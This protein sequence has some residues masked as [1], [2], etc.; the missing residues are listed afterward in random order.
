VP[1]VDLIDETFLVALPVV[2]AAACHD[3]ARTAAWWPDL[4]LTVFQDRGVDGIRW[5]VTGALVG[6]AELWLEATGDGVL[7]HVYIRA[8]PT[9][10]GSA[11][12]V[13]SLSVRAATRARARRARQI[14][15][16]SWRLKDELEAGRAAGEPRPGPHEQD[17]EAPS[18]PVAARPEGAVDAPGQPAPPAG[19]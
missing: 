1:Q 9:R 19:G 13:A 6:T 4:E 5:T 10:R 2:V 3:P 18:A 8:D 16:W 17:I 14:K 7:M 12:E 15:Q 11:T